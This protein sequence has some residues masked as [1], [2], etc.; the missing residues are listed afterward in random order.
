MA[1]SWNH[2]SIKQANFYKHITQGPAHRRC[3]VEVSFAPSFDNPILYAKQQI[4][5]LHLWKPIPSEG[6]S[7]SQTSFRWKQ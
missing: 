5:P 6:K 3:S 2:L 7:H 1:P 4:K